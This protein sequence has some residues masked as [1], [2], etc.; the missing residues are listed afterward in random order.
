[1][2]LTSSSSV[3]QHYLRRKDD[4]LRWN[5]QLTKKLKNLHRWASLWRQRC[6]WRLWASSLHC[7][8]GRRRNWSPHERTTY[9][10]DPNSSEDHQ[11]LPGGRKRIKSHFHHRWQQLSLPFLTHIASRYDVS[12]RTNHGGLDEGAPPIALAAHAVSHHG[13][14]GLLQLV[15]HWPMGWGGGQNI[16]SCMKDLVPKHNVCFFVCMSPRLKLFTKSATRGK[17]PLYCKGCPSQR[18]SRLSRGRASLQPL[19]DTP[20]PRCPSWWGSCPVSAGPGHC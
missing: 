10:P 8:S 3:V 9:H 7:R 16:T 18:C 11:S 1:M 14:Q 15:W 17:R 5:V 6:E 4:I 13:Q 20:P 2:S 19:G 12:S